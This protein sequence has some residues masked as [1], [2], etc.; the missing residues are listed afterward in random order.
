MVKLLQ[1]LAGAGRSLATRKKRTDLKFNTVGTRVSN[2]CPF[3]FIPPLADVCTGDG[4][5]FCVATN[6]MHF[7]SVSHVW[8]HFFIFIL[9][10]KVK[11]GRL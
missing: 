1:K 10:F 11:G 9:I 5:V 7:C 4:S 8:A 3:G 2:P 6:E